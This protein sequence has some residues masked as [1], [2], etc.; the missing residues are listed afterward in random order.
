MVCSAVETLFPPGVFTTIRP[1]LVAA[2]RSMLSY[3]PRSAD[4]LQS[5]ACLDHLRRFA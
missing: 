1:W 5:C 2:S 4:H 3:L